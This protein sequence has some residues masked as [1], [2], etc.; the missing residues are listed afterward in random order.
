MYHAINDL[1]DN[2]L[3]WLNLWALSESLLRAD[4]ELVAVEYFSAFYTKKADAY[5]RHRAYVKALEHTGVSTHMGN[6]KFKEIR[7]NGC[8]ATWKKPEEKETDVHI[9][10]RMVSDALLNR[11][12][13]CIL[14]SA[15]SDLVP[16]RDFIM[17]ECAGKEFFVAA[18]PHRLKC[19]RDLNPNLEITVGR[20]RKHLFPIDVLDNHGNI[21]V[22][23]PI[24]YRI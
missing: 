14:I 9:A 15:D 13:R 22:S 20:I 10:I 3:K 23:A 1:R 5:A 11:F 24:E 16:P 19:A 6:F 17:R 7:C 4:E 12:D 2:R 18:P 21:V 8:G